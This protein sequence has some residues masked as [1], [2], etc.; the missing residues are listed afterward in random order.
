M[1]LLQWLSC[2][3]RAISENNVFLCG[4]VMD[5]NLGLNV[6][7]ECLDKGG[8]SFPVK[9]VVA[10]YFLVFVGIVRLECLITLMMV[11]LNFYF[12]VQLGGYGL[13]SSI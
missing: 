8:E 2:V 11:L 13:C 9:V 5:N 10:L 1:M 3:W 7:V 6:L 4:A 12:Q